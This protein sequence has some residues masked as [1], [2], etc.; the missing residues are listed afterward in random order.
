MEINAI[1]YKLI[2]TPEDT[3]CLGCAFEDD[4]DACKIACKDTYCTRLNVVKCCFDNFI[5]VKE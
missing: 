3:G 1:K 5:W 4:H 2:Q